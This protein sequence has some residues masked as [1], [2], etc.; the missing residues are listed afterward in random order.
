[1]AQLQK[2]AALPVAV[3]FL[4]GTTFL[5]FQTTSAQEAEF[6]ASFQLGLPQGPFQDQLDEVGFGIQGMAGY[7]IPRT[8]VMFGLDFGFM[9]FAADRR[10]EPLSSTIPDVRVDVENSYNMAHGHFVTR[11]TS[12]NHHFRPYID[13][14]VGFNYLY[15]Q[16]TVR[17]RGSQEDVFTDTNFDDFAFSYGLGAGVRFLVW[18]GGGRQGRVYV[19]T[20]V[21]YMIGSEA[22]YI[23]PGSL[24]T[25]NGTVEYDLS[26]SRTDLLSIQL[27]A[28]FVIR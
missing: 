5:T 27:G 25:S 23:Q 26:S 14:L 1:M 20:Q 15:T 21:R 4:I 24:S 10:S 7:H 16:T 2:L 17:S 28:T 6:G 19:N 13:M 8:P 3:L 9:G 12:M 22:E 11:L 18:D